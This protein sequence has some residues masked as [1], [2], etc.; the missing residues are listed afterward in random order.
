VFVRNGTSWPASATTPTLAGQASAELFG[1][2][3]AVRRGRAII[4]APSDDE[5]GAFNCG[6]VYF[7]RCTAAGSCT[8]ER[9]AVQSHPGNGDRFGHSVALD[10]VTFAVGAPAEQSNAINIDGDETNDSLLAAGAVYVFR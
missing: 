7:F 3:V 6:A 5:G 4:G 9:R 2:S 8:L 1:F 10:N